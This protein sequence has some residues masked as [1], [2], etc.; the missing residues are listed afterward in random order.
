M[1][2][3]SLKL[4]GFRQMLHEF[5]GLTAHWSTLVQTKNETIRFEQNFK[6]LVCGENYRIKNSFLKLTNSDLEVPEVE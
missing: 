6:A 2:Q 4:W 1:L 3:K 5:Q